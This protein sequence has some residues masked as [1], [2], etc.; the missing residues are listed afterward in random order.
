MLIIGAGHAAV[1]AALAFRD[2]GHVGTVT[3]VAREGTDAPYERPPLSKWSDGDLARPIVPEDQL[4][5]AAINRITASVSSIDRKAHRVTLEDGTR[6]PYTRLLLATG[7]SAR[8]LDPDITNGAPVHYLRDLKDAVALR[9]NADGACSAIIIGGG[10]IGLELAASLRG[11]GID[12]RVLEAADR[13]LSRAV[14]PPVAR[15]VHRLHETNGVRFHFGTRLKSVEPGRVTLA[16]G[17]TLVADLVIAG[18][19]STPNTGLARDAGLVVDNGIRV[20]SFLQ[21]DDPDIYAAGDCCAF[22]LYG[23]GGVMTRLESWRAAGD[24]GTLAARNMIGPD[25]AGCTLTPWFWSEHYDHVLQVS[26]LPG[27]ETARAE[28]A[29]DDG[30]HV[31]FGLCDDGT[32]AFACGIA[33]GTRVAKDIRF[34]ARMIEAGTIVDAAQISDPALTLKSLLSGQGPDPRSHPL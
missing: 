25:P 33:P 10:F 26:G 30:H 34:A 24:Q 16:D 7:A 4:A 27:A 5:G 31:S 6:L 8:R 29:Y 22:P 2:A 12:V 28:R 32:L 19:G 15:I 18:I 23:A 21:T 11:I 20:N 14:S 3:M 1:R 13:L 9:Q 17:R